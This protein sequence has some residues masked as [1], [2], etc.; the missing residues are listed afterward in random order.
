MPVG[1]ISNETR[2]FTVVDTIKKVKIKRRKLTACCGCTEK[3]Q[4]FSV[5]FI[6]ICF[7]ELTNQ[8]GLDHIRDVSDSRITQTASKRGTV[9]IYENGNAPQTLHAVRD[10]N[11]NCITLLSALRNVYKLNQDEVHDP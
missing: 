3:S 7:A 6:F 11:L 9:H 2:N 8:T 5:H 1:N 4:S 10:L